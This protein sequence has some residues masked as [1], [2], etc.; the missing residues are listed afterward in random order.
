MPIYCQQCGLRLLTEENTLFCPTCWEMSPRIAR[1]FCTLCGRPHPGAVGFGTRSNFP[2]AACRERPNRHIRRL[3]G[4][5]YYDAAIAE[6]IKRFKFRDRPHLAGSLGQLLVEFAEREM[7]RDRYDLVVPVPLHRVRH[8]L[9]GYNQSFLL[10][11]R[12]L[13]VFPRARLDTSLKRIRPTR[14][15]SRLDEKQRRA[16]V[17]GAFAVLGDACGGKR[18]LLVDDVVTTNSTVTECAATLRRA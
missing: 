3:F 8:R 15:Q 13:P 6:T 4:A 7:E 1:P 2:C 12:V 10:A 16:N 5:A 17:R 9:R 11:E 18:V 14:T